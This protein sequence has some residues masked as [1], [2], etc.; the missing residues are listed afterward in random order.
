M[1]HKV[2]KTSDILSATKS[3]Y[4][5]VFIQKITTQKYFRMIFIKKY[6][7][8]ELNLEYRPKEYFFKLFFLDVPGFI[9]TSEGYM[10]ESCSTVLPGLDITHHKT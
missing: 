10:P 3:H 2:V 8:D 4:N 9:H 1:Y 7:S 5:S 6:L